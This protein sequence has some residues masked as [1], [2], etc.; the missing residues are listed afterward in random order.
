MKTQIK[1]LT[2][3]FFPA[4]L[5][6]CIFLSASANPIK[7]V[8]VKTTLL[9]SFRKITVTG[10]VQVTVIQIGK[11]G[12]AYADDSYGT[13][14][15][16]QQ[17]DLLTISPAD[18]SMA[19]VILYVKDIYRI[20]GNDEAL[21]R[22]EGLLKT[23]YL[24]V[25]LKGNAKADINTSTAGICTVLTD[26]AMLSLSGGTEN[27]SFAKSENSTLKL[28]SFAALKTEINRI[29]YPL[30]DQEIAAVK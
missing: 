30:I 17:G 27:H 10:N 26:N 24:Q 18:N 22:T 7:N 1:N 9:K 28:K 2:A 16:T 12:I 14:K 3:V 20:T 15:V 25:F 5:L 8:L 11:E 29:D 19:K 6:S 23:T 21:I 13:A 4:L